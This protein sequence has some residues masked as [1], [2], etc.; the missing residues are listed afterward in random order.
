[1]SGTVL[2]RRRQSES[3]LDLMTGAGQDKTTILSPRSQ[4]KSGTGQEKAA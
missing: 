3:I 2:D 1:M 4:A